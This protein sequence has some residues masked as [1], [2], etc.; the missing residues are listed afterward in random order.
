VTTLP[1]ILVVDDDPDDVTITRRELGKAFDTD[2]ASSA[3]AALER[4]RERAYD[5]VILDYRLG[6]TNALAFLR[7]SGTLGKVPVIVVSGRDDPRVASAAHQL[8]AYAFLAKDAFGGGALSAL[9]SEALGLA[10]PR[11]RGRPSMGV[12]ERMSEGLYAVDSD[13]VVVLA[14]P[15][16]ERLLGYG[17]RELLGLGLERVMGP[18]ALA[19]TAGCLASGRAFVETE[20]MTRSGGRLPALVSPTALAEPGGHV[21]VIRD[22][23]DMRTRIGDLERSNRRL[24]DDLV[25]VAAQVLHNVGNAAASLDVRVEDLARE[26]DADDEA[27]RV[28]EGAANVLEG[29]GELVALMR[30]AVR[31]LDEARSS[32]RAAVEAIRSGIN[33]IARAVDHARSFAGKTGKGAGLLDLAQAVETACALA[34]DLA[35]GRGLELRIARS[36]PAKLPRLPVPE[37]GFEQ[38]LVNVLKNAVESVAARAERDPAA[39]REVALEARVEGGRL[40][41]VIRDTGE[42]ATPEVTARAFRFGFTTKPEGSGFGL[43]A[44]ADFVE[45]LGGRIALESAGT[46]RGATVRVEI[47]LDRRGTAGAEPPRIDAA[48][49]AGAERP[50]T[51]PGRKGAAA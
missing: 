33:H 28:L 27:I 14:N 32:R 46:N 8:G 20:L 42:G 12:L 41:V 24:Q 23:R 19:A 31:S 43:H 34:E 51:D 4:L 21:A 26:L 22:F 18:D 13:G 39:P 1:R 5:L 47:P 50:T 10:R 11:E 48:R 44:S 49:S 16:L 3:E 7:E 37:A 25:E 45:R 40:E 30:D 15:A 38:L 2:D 6:G 17:P 9:A 35:R 36:V 29:Q